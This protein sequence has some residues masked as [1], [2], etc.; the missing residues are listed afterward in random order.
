MK[1]YKNVEPNGSKNVLQ[2]KK[3]PNHYLAKDFLQNY[4]KFLKHG[5]L[6]HQIEVGSV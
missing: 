5:I 1:N 6:I 2:K 4:R 3:T